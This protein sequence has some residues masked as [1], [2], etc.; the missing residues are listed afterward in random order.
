[1]CWLAAAAVIDWGARG[2]SEVPSTGEAKP[3]GRTELIGEI[4]GVEVD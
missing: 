2:I 3:P 4:T 1:M